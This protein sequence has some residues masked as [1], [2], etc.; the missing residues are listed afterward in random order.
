[1]LAFKLT[2]NLRWHR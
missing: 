1:M 2:T